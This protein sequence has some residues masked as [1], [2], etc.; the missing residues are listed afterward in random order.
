[1][2]RTMLTIKDKCWHYEDEVRMIRKTFGIVPINKSYLQ[3]VCFGLDIAESEIRLI[4]EI[5]EKFNYDVHFSR[6][7]RT[8]DD[9]G[10]RAVD[11]V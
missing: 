3:H 10:I 11:I 4:K 6:I 7:Q 5:I 2:F 1:M 9:F 8:Q